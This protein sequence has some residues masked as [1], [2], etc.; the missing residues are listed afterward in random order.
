MSDSLIAFASER[1]Y[2]VFLT[3][4]RNDRTIRCVDSASCFVFSRTALSR[5]QATFA[6][7]LQEHFK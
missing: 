4:L 6:E 7:K 5:A 3:D 1:V 2:D